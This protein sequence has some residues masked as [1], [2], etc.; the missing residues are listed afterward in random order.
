M[1]R[2][3]FH[4]HG[5]ITIE[6]VPDPVP[7]PGE[8]LL[9]VI[10]VGLC[11]SDR[12][13]WTNGSAVTPGHET[14]GRIVAAGP[15]TRGAHGV[16]GSVF[17][18]AWC[19]RCSRCRSGSRGACLSKEAMLGFDRDGGFAD[20]MVVP[21]RCFLPLQPTL[22]AETAVL[23]LDVTG[24]ALHALRRCGAF[25]TPPPAALVM[26]AGPLGLGCVMA[27]RA[28]GVERI[29]ALDPSAHRLAMAA[30]LGAELI[31]GDLD[32]AVQVHAAL[33]E[34]PPLVLEASG[35][36]A[37]QRQALDLVAPGGRLV[38]LGHSPVAMAVDVSRDLIAPEKQMLGSE[39]FDPAEYPHNQQ[40]VIDGRLEPSRAVTHRYP[41]D[42]LA[43]AYE[44]FWS[45]KSGKVLV[46]PD[47][48]VDA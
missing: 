39:Y 22:P 25:D 46:F 7:G 20:R 5:R 38:L 30:T 21:E 6:D 19:G 14:A 11:G 24:T 48:Q 43:Q 28:V 45:G 1:R 33:P 40:L 29:L 15:G 42:E 41:L 4:G 44:L 3:R 12:A 13:A 9:D 34:G 32:A 47:G 27:L 37:A 16:V 36:P 31:G 8:L 10:A 23:L 18:V 17:L 26:G 2:A 35:N